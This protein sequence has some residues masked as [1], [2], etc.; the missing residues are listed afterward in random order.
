MYKL[1]YGLYGNSKELLFLTFETAL[2]VAKAMSLFANELKWK[3]TSLLINS[4]DNYSDL[5]EEGF[6]N[7]NKY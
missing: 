6:I 7:I 3:R 1:E 4:E 5:Y 2:V